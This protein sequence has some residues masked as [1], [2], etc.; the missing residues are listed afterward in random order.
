MTVSRWAPLAASL[1]S[2]AAA[3][4]ASAGTA[5]VAGGQF[6][7]IAA[8]AESSFLDVNVDGAGTA[9]VF[10]RAGVVITAGANCS[11]PEG[12]NSATCTGITR[13]YTIDM[14]DLNDQV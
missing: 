6:T 14:G 10:E 11:N 9:Q 5:S 7:Y 2:L 3:A 13:A 8:P 4:P 12:D 1:L